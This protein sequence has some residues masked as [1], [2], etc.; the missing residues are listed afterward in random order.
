[1]PRFGG[2]SAAVPGAAITQEVVSEEAFVSTCGGTHP[3]IE[4]TV[5]TK[6]EVTVGHR[7]GKGAV[8]YMSQFEKAY[9]L[10]ELR[11]KA[12]ALVAGRDDRKEE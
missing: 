1:M 4:F 10:R 7:E 6:K 2:G 12:A 3:P 8:D 11:S 9:R 5:T